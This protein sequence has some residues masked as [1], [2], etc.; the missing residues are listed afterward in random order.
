MYRNS[1]GSKIAKRELGIKIILFPLIMFLA[2]SIMAPQAYCGKVY[3]P[4]G[5][6]ISVKF[7]LNL[8]TELKSKPANNEIFEIAEGRTISGIEVIQAGG[9]VFCEITKFK[10]P[11]LLGGGGEIEVRID[12]V[13]TALG[14][15]IAIESKILSHKGK[16]NRLKA[17]LMLPALGYG[18]LVKGENAD[19]GKQNDTINLKTSEL[20]SISF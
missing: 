6:D 5:T 1:M 3:I 16:S 11:G 17:I 10:K 19:L 12:S 15:N 8:S 4:K 20:N 7:K 18:L 9:E 13:R 2:F 14:K